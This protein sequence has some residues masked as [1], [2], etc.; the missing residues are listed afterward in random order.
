VLGIPANAAGLPP[1]L[2][3]PAAAH[4]QSWLCRGATCLPPFDSLAAL[5]QACRE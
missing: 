4:A 2:D 1:L 3:K 5:R